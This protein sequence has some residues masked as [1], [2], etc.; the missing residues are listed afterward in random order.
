MSP[1]KAKV[2][3]HD[4]ECVLSVSV[5]GPGLGTTRK[6]NIYLEVDAPGIKPTKVCEYVA[7]GLSNCYGLI[8]CQDSGLVPLTT[9]ATLAGCQAVALSDY[10]QQSGVQLIPDEE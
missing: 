7:T 1:L 8:R 5:G 6:L 9:C 3:I 10:I 4:H 2:L